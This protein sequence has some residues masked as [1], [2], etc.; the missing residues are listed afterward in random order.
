M[1]FLFL[2]RNFDFVNVNTRTSF[3]L[4]ANSSFNKYTPSLYKELRPFTRRTSLERTCLE[5]CIFC[6]NLLTTNCTTVHPMQHFTAIIISSVA[7]L[8]LYFLY[9]HSCSHRPVAPTILTNC[10]FEFFLPLYAL[11]HLLG[12]FLEFLVRSS[13][14]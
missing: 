4:L 8:I 2:H 5:S 7:L 13:F 11:A 12:L 1:I 14:L 9:D 10:A 6:Y 3:D